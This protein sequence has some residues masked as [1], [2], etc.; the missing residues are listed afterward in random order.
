MAE[1]ADF[2]HRIPVQIRFCDLDGLNHV[3]NANYLSYIELARIDY[4]RSVLGMSMNDPKGVILAKATVDY[5]RP[6]LLD[7]KIEIRT[8]AARLGNKSFD[9]EYVMV[10]IDGDTETIMATAHTVIVA[11]DYEQNTT[12]QLLD[13]WVTKM[14]DYD[15]VA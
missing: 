15:G 6:I 11:F 3:N 4:F 5:L 8:R 1:L 14:K 7:D 10:K 2:K 13:S 12:M 9:L